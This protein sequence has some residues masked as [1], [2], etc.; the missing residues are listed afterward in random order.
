MSADQKDPPIPFTLEWIPD[1]LP[2][3]QIGE[4]RMRFQYGHERNGQAEQ[5][6]AATSRTTSN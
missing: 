2:K 6:P 5:R 4:L 1:V 3:S